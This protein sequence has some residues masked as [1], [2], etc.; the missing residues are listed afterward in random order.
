ML[1]ELILTAMLN[2]SAPKKLRVFVADD[3]AIIRTRLTA[4]LGRIKGVEIV[5]EAENGQAAVMGIEKVKP[6]VVLL[7]LNMPDG[8]GISV[9]K[10]LGEKIGRLRIVVL[11]NYATPHYRKKCL[12]MGAERFFDKSSEFTKAIDFVQR[13]TEELRER[14]RA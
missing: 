14:E 4:M 13:L 8:S 12:E 5:G 2:G 7:D 10:A 6:D 3:A 9:L 1:R 11:T